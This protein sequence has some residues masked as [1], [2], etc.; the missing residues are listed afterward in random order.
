MQPFDSTPPTPP[1]RPIRAFSYLAVLAAFF[2]SA[3]PAGATG[4]AARGLDVLREQRCVS[5]HAIEPDAMGM[6]P[7]L[8]RLPSRG[9]DPAAF[10]AMLWNH[11]PSMWSALEARNIESPQPSEQAMQDL[12]A[13]F[14]SLR[15]FDPPGDAG[16]G[17]RAFRRNECVQCHPLD[18]SASP[19]PGAK[20]LSEW[21]S[22]TDPVARVQAMWNHAAGMSAEMERRGVPW[23]RMEARE[24]ADL[25]VFLRA[26]PNEVSGQPRG[27]F[28]DVAA[29]E[30]VLQERGC[31]RCHS[32]GEKVSGKLDLA[33]VPDDRRNLA[34][35]GA[36]MW[37]HQPRLNKRAE[38]LQSELRPFETQEMADLIAYLRDR[39]LFQPFGDADKGA[40]V[41]RKGRC[42][43][44]HDGSGSGAPSLRG[45][46]RLTPEHIA[47]ALWRHG[48]TM[49][50]SMQKQGLTWPKF[51]G[52]QL[53][54]LIAYINER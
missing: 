23:P 45:G 7:N 52:E 14:Y 51:S 43:N 34:A 8:A 12:F 36:A 44:C 22:I 19:A 10:T 38:L 18:P 1:A 29:G 40:R 9:L 13:Y 3:A 21:V 11:A 32:L 24:M 5:C 48:P 54:D 2:L 26:R 42:A 17:K 47:S 46:Q 37:N 16:R 33:A 30:R 6:A 20:P 31:V 4:D 27:A 39:Q 15:Y 28:G 41:F 50:D 25:W 49:L 53:G 35:F